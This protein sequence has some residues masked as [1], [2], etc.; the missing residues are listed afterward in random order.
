MDKVPQHLMPQDH[1]P[2]GGVA[3]ARCDRGITYLDLVRP[4]G[5]RRATVGR[6]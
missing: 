4:D 6:R 2:Q 5:D 1:R 3:R